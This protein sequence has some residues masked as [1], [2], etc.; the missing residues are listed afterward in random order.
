MKAHSKDVSEVVHRNIF[1]STCAPPPETVAKAEIG[2]P[3]SNE[4]QKT[5]LQLELVSTMVCP[6]DER[7]SMAVLRDLSTKE[8]DPAMFAK[9]AA[10]F[11]TGAT[12]W[13]VVE[14]RVYLKNAGHTEYVEL[15][16]AAPAAAP[17]TSAPPPPTNGNAG[18]GEF[19]GNVNCS[20]NN[21]TI[22]RVF[23]EKML[24]NTAALATA[25]R[26]VP[27]I[28]DGKPSGFRLYA[29]RPNSIFAKLGLQNGDTIKSINGTEMTSLEKGLELFTKL[30]SASHITVQA[31]RARGESVTLDYT[32][33]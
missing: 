1:C 21:C 7:W 11:S 15:E 23:V 18:P 10:I 4:P 14:K 33:K 26:A 17:G 22:D 25:A 19:D 20:G 16:G 3:P 13:K 8:K 24:N 31:E 6:S 29:I 9:G 12:V 28:K 2:G 27:A 30:R 5:S 32:I